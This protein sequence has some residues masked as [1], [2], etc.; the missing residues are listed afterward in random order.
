MTINTVVDITKN[1]NVF[2]TET[3]NDHKYIK[4]LYLSFLV[5]I[6][7]KKL[8]KHTDT[9]YRMEYQKNPGVEA[10][11]TIFAP[12]KNHDHFMSRKSW[13]SERKSVY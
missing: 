9:S 6:Y 11:K 12:S 13:S 8:F 4:F 10:Q 1:W 3:L 7:G 5:S 2:E